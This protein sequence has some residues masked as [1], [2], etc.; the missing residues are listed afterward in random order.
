MSASGSPEWRHRQWSWSSPRSGRHVGDADGADD[1]DCA[2]QTDGA[3]QTQLLA[4]GEMTR[5]TVPA[6]ADADDVALVVADDVDDAVAVEEDVA[7]ADA[8]DDAVAV[9]EDVAVADADADADAVAVGD[10]VVDAVAETV[11]VAVAEA[12]PVAVTG[13]T[14]GTSTTSPLPPG[15]TPVGELAEPAAAAPS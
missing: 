5:T 6:D 9:E 7:V 15:E 3:G 8:V 12:V 13:K 1:G 14:N 2:G 4:L 10:A 11:S